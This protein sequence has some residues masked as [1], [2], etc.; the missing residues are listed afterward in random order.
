MYDVTIVY[1]SYIENKVNKINIYSSKQQK[2]PI[3]KLICFYNGVQDRADCTELNLSTA[4]P[5]G[6][7]PD[8]NV[9]VKMLNINFG[10]NM[11]L[12]NACQPLWD[13]SWLIDKII[14]YKK[15]TGSVEEAVDRAVDDLPEKS[16]IKGFL[17]ENKAEV[18]R[19]C[20][21]EYDEAWTMNMFSVFNLQSVF[22]YQ[23]LVT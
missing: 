4:F 19:M 7:D 21:T 1:S 8:I 6:S 16:V 22:S 18:K 10:R 3:P 9:K 14:Q 12:L 13:Y 20:I 11:E 15:E 17:L 2:L 5:E 23:S